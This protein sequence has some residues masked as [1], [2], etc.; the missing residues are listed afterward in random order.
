M[1]L[2]FAHGAH[3]WLAADAATTT[4]AITGLGFQPKALRFYT[5]GMASDV[6]ASSTTLHVRQCIGFATSASDRRCVAAQ[7]QDA[8]ADSTCTS[9]VRDDA[10][11]ATV[12][13]TGPA[14]DGLLD[15]QSMDSDGFT[16]VVDDQ[17]PVDLM[18]FWEAW[19]GADILTAVTLEFAE[20]SATGQQTYSAP[21]LISGNAEKQVVMFAG[22]Q[23][24]GTTPAV[25]R[26]SSAIMVG[27]A[28]SAT[29]STVLVAGGTDAQASN[30][31]NRYNQTG[32]CVAMQVASG[33][34][35]NNPSARAAFVS[36][37]TDGFTLDW[38]ARATT[39]R[40]YIALA[41]KGGSWK[42]NSG[43]IARQTL[44][45]TMAVSGLSFTPKGLHMMFSG[46]GVVAAGS[47][48]VGTFMG[49]GTAS[50]T[51]SRRC[52]SIY[53]EQGAVTMD[54]ELAVEYDQ[55]GILFFSGAMDSLYDVSAF[56]SDGFTLIVDDASAF[57]LNQW[58]AYLTFGDGVSEI[59]GTASITLDNTTLVATGTAE[60]PTSGPGGPVSRMRYHR[61]HFGG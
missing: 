37:G 24:T 60:E 3:K 6:D 58:M 36:F 29:D 40:K 26:S 4:Y 10:V 31:T 57:S 8:A 42:T 50:S 35:S 19:G 17:S 33:S 46:L 5:N 18:V 49:M 30:F 47:G 34:G 48:T 14:V 41:I 32:E 1:A 22:C 12:T 38:L 9:A 16:L 13:A 55:L 11:V 53:Q 23:Q 20:P 39:G 59:Q 45:A 15:L 27:F 51:S 25:S 43:V 28:T 7:D 54:P 52:M 2:S 44:N 61:H 56:A 21:G